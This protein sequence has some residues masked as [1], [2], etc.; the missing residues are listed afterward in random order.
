MSG[1]RGFQGMPGET[2]KAGDPGK[3]GQAGVP[4]QP[5]NFL[6]TYSKTKRHLRAVVLFYWLAPSLSTPLILTQIL[7]ATKLIICKKR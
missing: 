1:Q 4:G 5:G 3:D 6:K 2:G 7:L